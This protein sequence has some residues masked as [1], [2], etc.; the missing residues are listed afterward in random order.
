MA[1][2]EDYVIAPASY[3]TLIICAVS[4]F[5]LLAHKRRHSA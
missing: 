4:E 1:D 5:L 3:F 2:D